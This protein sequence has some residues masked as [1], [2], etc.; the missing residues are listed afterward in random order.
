MAMPRRHSFRQT[1]PIPKI[2]LMTDP[3]LGKDLL[4]AIQRLPI[5][6]GVV[7]RHYE[8][9]EGERQRL[10]A[11]VRRI[12]ARRGHMLLRAGMEHGRIA[13]AFSA[14][15]HNVKELNE[16]RRAQVALVFISPLYATNSHPGAKALGLAH[17]RQL[18]ALAKPAKVIALG[19]MTGNRARPLDKGLVHG[20]AA[21][22]A[23][24]K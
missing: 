15:V 18:A 23:F 24:R 17:F 22:D 16:A 7:F 20:W 10:L 5:H 14:P 19:G 8:L 11:K 4:A 13:G 1:G 21:I 2:W 12:C 6:S 3:R 9:G